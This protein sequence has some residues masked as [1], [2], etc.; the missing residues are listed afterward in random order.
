TTGNV[1]GARIGLHAI[2]FDNQTAANDCAI[3]STTVIGNASDAGATCPT[4]VERIGRITSINTG[5]GTLAVVDLQSWDVVTP[6][7][8]GFVSVCASANSNAL[9]A[10]AGN[11]VSCDA[12]VTDDG[13]G[14][15]TMKSLGLT[16]AS[17]A[18][19]FYQKQGTAPTL[20][21][22]NSVYVHPP[23]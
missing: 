6:A 7:S 5:A 3:P 18:G 13:A 17:Q 9:F 4:G 10:L 1:R 20:S 8:S 15:M 11:T 21:A 19:F 2:I 23:A 14:N 16:D 22:T 12:L